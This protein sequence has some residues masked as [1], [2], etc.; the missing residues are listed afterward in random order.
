MELEAMIHLMSYSPMEKT[1]FFPMLRLC[2]KFTVTDMRQREDLIVNNYRSTDKAQC[3]RKN[4]LVRY[5]SLKVN[6]LTT[7]R[8]H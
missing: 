5:L 1:R 2:V 8:N 4:G 7:L 3:K 6:Y